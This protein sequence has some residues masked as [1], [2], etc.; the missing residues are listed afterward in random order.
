MSFYR[1]RVNLTLRSQRKRSKIDNL[2]M[3]KIAK[4]SRGNGERFSGECHIIN[5][6]I[7]YYFS[8]FNGTFSEF[9]MLF[10]NL[11]NAENGPCQ[12][13]NRTKQHVD[14][15]KVG[16]FFRLASMYLAPIDDPYDQ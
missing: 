7:F 9:L 3:R 14:F 4:L 16:R 13:K 10:C 8:V 6:V 1:A 15:D 11:P 5:M 12:N 2:K